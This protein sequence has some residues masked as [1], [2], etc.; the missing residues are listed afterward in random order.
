M[1]LVFLYIP[2]DT[3]YH[4]QTS[5][6]ITF[7]QSEEGHLVENKHNAEEDESIFSSIDDLF[8]D[9]DS[10]DRSISTNHLEDIQYGS[11]IHP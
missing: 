8:T 6:V 4:E 9:N 5:K 2:Y 10:D 11:Q 7:G 3:S 1:R